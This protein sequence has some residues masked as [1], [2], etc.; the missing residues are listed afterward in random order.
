MIRFFSIRRNWR[1]KKAGKS[2]KMFFKLF[3]AL[4]RRKT[5]VLT[6]LA[7]GEFF[8]VAIDHQ[9]RVFGIFPLQQQS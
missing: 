8:S 6:S 2:Q 7:E 9:C 5:A 3:P 1:I 4:L